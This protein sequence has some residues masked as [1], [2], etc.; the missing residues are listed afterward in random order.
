MLWKREEFL[1]HLCF[2]H[3]EREMIVEMFGLLIGTEPCWREQGASNEEVNLSAFAWDRVKYVTA[4][5]DKWPRSGLKETLLSEDDS[6]R[7]IRDTFGRTMV[8]P[9]KVATIGLPQDFPMA[10]AGD[11]DRVSDWF[12][13]EADRVDEKALATCREERE[14]GGVVRLYIWGAYDIMRQLMGDENACV[15]LSDEP[16]AIRKILAQIGDMQEAS[17]R[18]IMQTTPID[19]LF[20]HEDFAGRSGPLIGPKTI[21][22]LFNPYYRRMWA[23]AQMGGARIFDIDSDGYVDPV[24]DALLESGINCLHPVQPTGG[25]DMVKL[26]KKYGTRLTLRGGI[27]KFA[28]TRGKSAID[29]ELDYRLDPCLRGGGTMFGLDHRIPLEVSLEAYRYYVDGLRKR[30][31]LPPMHKDEP[32]WCRMA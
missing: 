22:E 26:R 23:L 6:T 4:P 9:K 31:D 13:V 25:T 30:L 16:D 11:W 3:S 27:D 24:I 7:V 2:G 32:G 20:V 12:R 29:E 17:I 19:I 14:A 5:M 21:R 15:A 28:L 1:S 18:K 10:E 8:L